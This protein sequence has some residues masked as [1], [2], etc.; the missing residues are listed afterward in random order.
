MTRIE[1]LYK[2]Y[3]NFREILSAKEIID[4]ACPGR[5][6]EGE[7]EMSF[8]A[9]RHDDKERVIGCRGISCDECW[10]REVNAAGPEETKKE[11]QK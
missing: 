10:N 3:P 4:R 7:P 5:L 9:Q 2:K 6:L 11:A 8:L 1:A